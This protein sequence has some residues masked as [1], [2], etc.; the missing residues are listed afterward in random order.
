M[1]WVMLVLLILFLISLIIDNTISK[2]P[3]KHDNG[4]WRWYE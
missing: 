4:R 2:K 1:R 3:I